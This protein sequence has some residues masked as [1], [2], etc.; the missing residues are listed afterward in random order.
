[1]AP[2]WEGKISPV[3]GQNS[4]LCHP[5][6]G[7]KIP[8]FWGQ[9][10]PHFGGKSPPSLGGKVPS[11]FG[12]RG[13][14]WCLTS[15]AHPAPPKIGVTFA[16]KMGGLLPPKWGD[17]CTQNWGTFA[18]QKGGQRGEFCP[19]TGDFSIPNGGHPS[20]KIVSTPPNN[21]GH[22]FPGNPPAPNFLKNA[23][24]HCKQVAFIA[25]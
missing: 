24:H 6:W 5:F 9:K 19:Q 22:L 20:P 2:I 17:F 23:S 15:M 14:R 25:N 12:G 18:P 4:P 11:I 8:Q 21:I 16:P 10:S 3:L 13:C 1:M 7:A